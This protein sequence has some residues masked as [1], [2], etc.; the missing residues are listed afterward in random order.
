MYLR[1]VCHEDKAL[2]GVVH[3]A[4]LVR[5]PYSPRPGSGS[6]AV[7][8][9]VT[10]QELS[11][12]LKLTVLYYYAFA[13]PRNFHAL[14]SLSPSLPGSLRALVRALWL[15]F[16]HSLRLSPLSLPLTLSAVQRELSFSVAVRVLTVTLGSFALWTFVLARDAKV[17]ERGG[18]GLAGCGAID[19][20]SLLIQLCCR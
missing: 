16:S 20:V 13:F 18:G 1:I 17:A 9:G 2:V 3:E 4:A 6:V 19:A 8:K 5:T 12:L 14:S 11:Q 10:A 15:T 7:V